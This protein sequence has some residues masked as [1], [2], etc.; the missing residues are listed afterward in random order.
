MCHDL[1]RLSSCCED[2]FV[3]HTQLINLPSANT[4][5]WGREE[6]GPREAFLHKANLGAWGSLREGRDT[7]LTFWLLTTKESTPLLHPP[8][9]PSPFFPFTY[10]TSPQDLNFPFPSSTKNRSDRT[11]QA[12]PVGSLSTPSPR[13]PFLKNRKHVLLKRVM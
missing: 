5:A 4:G 11:P 10:P 1:L 3:Y 13:L 2:L 8:L 7:S 12:T 6:R 9:L